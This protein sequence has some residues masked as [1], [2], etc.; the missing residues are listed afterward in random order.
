MRISL[1]EA[2]II[3]EDVSTPCQIKFVSL[4]VSRKKGG[5]LIELTS[6][7]RVG[8]SHNRKQNNTIVMKQTGNDHHPHTIHNYLITEVNKHEVFI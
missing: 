6:A 8:A 1:S 5:E 3:T 7:V 2:L 4:D